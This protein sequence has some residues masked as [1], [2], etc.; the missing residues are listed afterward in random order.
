MTFRVLITRTPERAGDLIHE[1]ARRGIQSFA[2][3]TTE[4]ILTI[5]NN[6]VPDLS[7]FHWLAFTSVNGVL[8]FARALED[9]G[10]KLPEGI[11]IAAVGGQTA[12]IAA[13]K[14]RAA[15]LVPSDANSEMLAQLIIETSKDAK[16]V[17][18]MWACAEN[19]LPKFGIALTAAGISLKQWTCYKTIPLEGKVLNEN[20]KTKFPWD[21]ALFAAPSAVRSFSAAWPERDGFI[22]CAIGTTTAATLRQLDFKNIMISKGT[23]VLETARSII[24]NLRGRNLIKS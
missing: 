10:W 2:V 11:R 17:A 19:A 23:G 12:R 16:G 20:L 24:E 15:D 22:S 4:T 9:N 7:E 5:E 21:L 14:L 8:A 13:E 18:V 1:L 6:K 3:P